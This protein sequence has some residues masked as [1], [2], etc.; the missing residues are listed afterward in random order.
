VRHSVFII[1]AAATG[2]SC[3]LKSLFETYKLQKKKPVWAD[4]NPK[5]VTNHEL[6]GYINLATREW[7]DGLFSSIMRDIAN[8]PNDSPKW[9]VLDGDIDTMWIESL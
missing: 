4:L 3:V 2:K 6:Y 1:G 8:L 9:I 7:V 5:A